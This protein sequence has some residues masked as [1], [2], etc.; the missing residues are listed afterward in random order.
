MA[1]TQTEQK[2][3]PSHAQ[4]RLEERLPPAVAERGYELLRD[5]SALADLIARAARD[6]PRLDENDRV[7]LALA[8]QDPCAH[9]VATRA[10]DGVTT[11]AAGMA[12]ALPTVPFTRVSA[13]LE[14]RATL[15]QASIEVQ[16]T[17]AEY[18]RSPMVRAFRHPH[19]VTREEFERLRK[20]TPLFSDLLREDVKGAVNATVNAKPP[21]RPWSDERLDG[22]WRLYMRGVLSLTVDGFDC[23]I[24]LLLYAATSHDVALSSRAIWHMANRPEETLDAIARRHEQ[25][26]LGEVMTLM[27]AF[28]VLPALATRHPAYQRDAL[29]L[30]AAL[31]PL[32]TTPKHNTLR[33]RLPVEVHYPLVT[34]LPQLLP[35]PWRDMSEATAERIHRAGEIGVETLTARDLDVPLLELAE[36]ISPWHAETIRVWDPLRDIGAPRQTRVRAT[37]SLDDKERV[38][39]AMWRGMLWERPLPLRG[40]DSYVA[41]L[42]ALAP[43]EAF[44]PLDDPDPALS[45]SQGRSYLMRRLF[46]MKRMG[47]LAREAREREEGESESGAPLVARNAPCLCGSGKKLKRCCGLKSRRL[48]RAR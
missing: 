31:V 10:G 4:A 48:R 41:M 39:V 47:R 11:L 18:D 30:A 42:V 9:L 13:F 43:L 38:R 24:R 8:P 22:L 3:S 26:L 25:K 1:R 20:L 33:Q 14:S 35:A 44:A 37:S 17:L 19:R 12:H 7:A 45:L 29:R 5:R 21:R 6:D 34:A 16:K 27:A 36:A 46:Q 40:G 32:L 15:L 2:R 28:Y 23:P